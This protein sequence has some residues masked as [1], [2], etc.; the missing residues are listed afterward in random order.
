MSGAPFFS[1]VS[2]SSS[3]VPISNKA[4]SRLPV[5]GGDVSSSAFGGGS[6]SSFRESFLS[7]LSISPS[8]SIGHLSSSARSLRSADNSNKIKKSSVGVST[9]QPFQHIEG[10]RAAEVP[11]SADKT[12]PSWEDASRR[13]LSSD[14]TSDPSL[15]PR[16]FSF[17]ESEKIS[18]ELAN[19]LNPPKSPT[20][21]LLSEQISVGEQKNCARWRRWWRIIIIHTADFANVSKQDKQQTNKQ[22]HRRVRTPTR[23]RVRA[24]RRARRGSR[25]PIL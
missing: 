18:S 11:P 21:S 10:F 3:S 23:T 15:R 24:R 12:P 5:A 7:P 19:I 22:R 6:S 20:R 17:G 1:C 25:Q 8:P 9:G 13:R 2:S 16:G 14:G 4:R